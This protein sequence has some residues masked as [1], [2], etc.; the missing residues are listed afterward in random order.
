[1]S[2]WVGD[3]KLLRGG[4]EVAA[5]GYCDLAVASGIHRGVL[6]MEG[7]FSGEWCAVLQDRAGA[8][9]T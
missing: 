2:G 4:Y 6:G 7:I 1:V 5:L 3:M 8:V 9:R